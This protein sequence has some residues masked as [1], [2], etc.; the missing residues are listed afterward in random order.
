MKYIAVL[1]VL[2]SVSAQAQTKKVIADKII[3][4]VGD[5]I[6]LKSDLMNALADIRRQGGEVP[7]DAECYIMQS[8]LIKKS[9]VIQAEKDSIVVGD[10]EIEGLLENQIRGFINEYG[11]K[12]ALDT[13]NRKNYTG[14]SKRIL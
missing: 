11:S 8:E 6:I 13:G 3:A 12:E 7:P 2:I 4:K 1:L 14:R 9:L 10:D 5:R